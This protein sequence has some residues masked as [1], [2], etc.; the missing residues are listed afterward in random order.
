MTT[1]VHTEIRPFTLEVPRPS[2]RTCATGSREPPGPK[3]CPA[4]AGIVECR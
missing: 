3:S 4:A 1:A 2:S